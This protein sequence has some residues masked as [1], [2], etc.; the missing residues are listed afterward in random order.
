MPAV[1][2]S[3]A[4]MNIG[5]GAGMLVLEEM[6]RAARRGATIYAE[7]AG[8]GLVRGVPSDGARARRPAGRDRRAMALAMRGSM[9]TRSTTSTRT[10][11]PR[12]R[13]IRPRR[14]ASRVVFGER[15]G[16]RSRQLDQV[17]DRPLPR[18][19]RRGR[20]RD[21]GA[22]RGARRHPRRRSITTRPIRTV[23]STSSRTRRARCRFAA[24]SR[25]RSP[26]AATTR[27]WS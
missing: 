10:A 12:R 16:R 13:T 22:D 14:K 1:R 25:R 6:D 26:S 20:G 3:R 9:R 19:G 8:Y 17:D 24:R 23:R 15:V 11:R 7:L 27:R 5:E 4:G 21:D 18:R 2:R